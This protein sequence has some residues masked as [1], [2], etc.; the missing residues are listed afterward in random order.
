MEQ[1]AL[2]GGVECDEVAQAAIE[3]FQGLHHDFAHEWR[4]A[5]D[6]DDH[7]YLGNNW[8]NSIN[9]IRD[10]SK[11]LADQSS[12]ETFKEHSKIALTDKEK[13]E[14]TRHRRAIVF[15]TKLQDR[16]NQ[17]AYRGFLHYFTIRQFYPE[18][19]DD[20]H[21]T[22]LRIDGLL[23]QL[24]DTNTNPISLLPSAAYK[25]ISTDDSL[26]KT[27]RKDLRTGL[28][29]VLRTGTEEDRAPILE[30]TRINSERSF[31][32]YLSVL[33]QTQQPPFA[34]FRR[35]DDLPENV[36]ILL[37]LVRSNA[38]QKVR[39]AKQELYS[40]W[41]TILFGD[42]DKTELLE[43]LAFDLIV[44]NNRTSNWGSLEGIPTPH[45]AAQ[46]TLLSD[47]ELELDPF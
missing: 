20:G 29:R 33:A 44:N 17:L 45:G 47:I 38:R 32:G 16:L 7:K 40:I 46:Q 2:L 3:H 10:S 43:D 14:Y 28:R 13:E 39:P 6:D 12:T 24:R 5:M 37:K 42:N 18:H 27:Q 8:S 19:I 4:I 26:E 23:N 25:L 11:S 1:M 34:R 15:N 22:T 30:V 35:T 31:D 41:S 21:E 36:K 9:Q